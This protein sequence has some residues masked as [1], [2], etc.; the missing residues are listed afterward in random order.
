MTIKSARIYYCPQGDRREKWLTANYW[1]WSEWF[2]LRLKPI[3]EQLRGVEV[4]DMD[5]VNLMLREDA[6]QA[7]HPN[8]W[9]QRG[10]ALMLEFICDLK[11]L[12]TGNKMENIQN[13]MNFYASVAVAVPWPQMK[14][15]AAALEVP[16]SAS[17]KYSLEPYL[18]W[19]RKVGRITRHLA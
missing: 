12:E 18:Q 4:K 1:G 5:I 16:L 8:V 3:R 6:S 15:V 13:L 11:P 19:P 14:S 7:W 10:N 9:K 17:D 2:E